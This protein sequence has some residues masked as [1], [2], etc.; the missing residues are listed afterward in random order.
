LSKQLRG[1][2]VSINRLSKNL[3]RIS[4][5]IPKNYL[6]IAYLCIGLAL[7]RSVNR[8][9]DGYLSLR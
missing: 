8:C 1:Y 2:V 3:L 9:R 6:S 4:M 7:I 5:V